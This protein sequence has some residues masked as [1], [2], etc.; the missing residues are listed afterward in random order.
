[1]ENWRSVVRVPA[2]TQIFLSKIIIIVSAV[3][4]V[5]AICHMPRQEF[6]L[7][8]HVYIHNK[9]KYIRGSTAPKSQNRLKWLLPDGCTGGLVV[10]KALIPQP[11]FQFS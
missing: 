4:V 11:S 2:M 9:N 6:S 1:M 8:K 7:Y 5:I 3:S 10:S